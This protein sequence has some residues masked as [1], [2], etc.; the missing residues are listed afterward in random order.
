[1]TAQFSLLPA[2]TV[3][4]LSVTEGNSGVRTMTFTVTLEGGA[5]EAS[6]ASDGR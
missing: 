1:V 6:P 2:L 3:H 4:D 5:S